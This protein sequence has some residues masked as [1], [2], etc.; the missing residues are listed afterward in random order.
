MPS[1]EKLMLRIRVGIVVSALAL[2]IASQGPANAADAT[3][4]W[5]T[6]G[7]KAKV[8]V[9]PCGGELCGTIVALAQPIDP[10]TGRPMTDK[11]ND[12]P[13]RRSRPLIGTRVLMGMKPDGASKW[14][15]RIYDAKNGKTV[16]G[17]IT[18]TGASAL[19]LEGCAL[20]GMICRSQT[21]T[22][23]N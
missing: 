2:A 10:A 11:H 8:R 1:E 23:A 17:S 7:G 5:S 14:V 15:G 6:D 21:W 19:K 9:A 20:G 13:A 4:L 16:S 12:D 22:R 3:G 18:L